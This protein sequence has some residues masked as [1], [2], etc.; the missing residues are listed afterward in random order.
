MNAPPPVDGIRAVGPVVPPIQFESS[1]GGGSGLRTALIASV[2]VL[3]LVIAAVV[4]LFLQRQ[5][6][7]DLGIPL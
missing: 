7:I 3:L 2:V 1:G 4:L 5:G 6:T